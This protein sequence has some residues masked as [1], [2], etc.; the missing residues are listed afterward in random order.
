MGSFSLETTPPV[1]LWKSGPYYWN[2]LSNQQVYLLVCL[3]LREKV[4]GRDQSN[5]SRKC[6]L[7]PIKVTPVSFQEQSVWK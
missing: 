6:S 7:K 3:F 5:H 1:P 4:C 2:H